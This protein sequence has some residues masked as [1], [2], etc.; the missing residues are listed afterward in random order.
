MRLDDPVNPL[1]VF[2]GPD[3]LAQYFN[4]DQN[5]LLPLIELPDA[6]NPLRS[7]GVRIFAK[8][9]TALPAQNVKSLPALRMLQHQPDAQHQS[10]VEASSG[11]TVL[12][13]AV[14]ARVLWG[15]E[16]VSGYV[17]NKKHP[18]SL[19]LLRFFGVQ[20]VLYGG[21]SQQEPSD[22]KGI[23]SR[24][25][26]QAAE[27]PKICYP[28]QYDNDHNWKA[29]E[30]WTGPQI[31]KQ[32]PEINVLCATIGTGGCITGTSAHLKSRKPS[33]RTI[34]V[35]NTFGDPT[36]GPRHFPGFQTSP[37]PWK[38]AIDSFETVSSADAFGT[39]IQ[40]CRHGIIAGPSSG[41]ALAGLLAHLGASKAQGRLASLGD[42]STGE[43]VCVFICA[44]LPYQYMDLYFSKLGEGAFPP[45]CNENLLRCDVHPYDERWFLDPQQAVSLLLTPRGPDGAETDAGLL[46]CPSPSACDCDS[47]GASR[48]DH[49][50]EPCHCRSSAAPAS[51]TSSTTGR[52]SGESDGS[53]AAT[54][55]GGESSSPGPKQYL[56]ASGTGC[57]QTPRLIDL[58]PRQAFLASHVRGSRN[59]ALPDT[60]EDFYGSA[61]AVEGR[62]DELNEV[63]DAERG[64]WAG[65][66]AADR[67]GSRV[68]VVCTDGDSSRMATSIL[69]ARGH[70]A[71]CVEGGYTALAEGIRRVALQTDRRSSM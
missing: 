34:G 8:M 57:W 60:R 64:T 6:L 9:L 56:D 42:P 68:L 1:N 61:A 36:P 2:K 29:H 44:D 62:W 23:M 13:L 11:S 70:E 25:R 21:A 4:P 63:L 17:T 49:G 38:T 67:S 16:D 26:R 50:L 20:P 19:R 3:S 51:A 58:R 39:S 7:D 54:S 47:D 46:L 18:D 71:V 43:V 69:R 22:A 40:L 30:K 28:G 66:F 59:L 52:Y 5:P 31:W 14:M 55:I 10:I 37:F 35:C 41:E 53:T 45:V 27:D 32:L 15:H 24:L 33:V 12:S 48:Q 65:E